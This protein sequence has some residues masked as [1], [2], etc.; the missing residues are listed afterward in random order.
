MKKYQLN[1]VGVQNISLEEAL[2]IVLSKTDLNKS[3]T[4]HTINVDHIDKLIRF[5]DKRF[6]NAYQKADIVTLDSRIIQKIINFKGN[7]KVNVCTGS[8]LTEFLF[9]KL[10]SYPNKSICI[11]GGNKK[12]I[13]KLL[14]RFK[15]VNEIKQYIP[16]MGFI[17]DPEE[18]PKCLKFINDNRFDIVFVAVGCPQQE[19]L[20]SYLKDG[21]I[22]SSY[23]LCVGAAI[24]FLTGVQN[25]AP[26]LIQRLHLEWAH[27]L[28]KNPKRMAKRYFSN[29]KTI[30]KIKFK[31]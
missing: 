12:S 6:N 4:I 5:E 19:I 1:D 10:S 22:F 27:R 18:F 20:A 23:Y 7:H 28:L 26:K 25:R 9:K 24:D 16:P 29:L 3:K 30:T 21:S 31:K 11:I 15:L 13:A 14:A 17:N 8:D 2:E